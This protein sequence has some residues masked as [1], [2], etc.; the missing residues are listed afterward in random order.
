LLSLGWTPAVVFIIYIA[1]IIAT[2]I[3]FITICRAA[4]CIIRSYEREYGEIRWRWLIF[5]DKFAEEANEAKQALQDLED[6]IG[7]AS[8]H[9]W[10]EP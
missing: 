10:E 5:I 9:N 2:A 6:E 7:Q 3:G 4:S 1:V 8:S